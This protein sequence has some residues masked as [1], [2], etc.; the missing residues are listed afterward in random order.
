MASFAVSPLTPVTQRPYSNRMKIA[1]L[2]PNEVARLAALRRAKILDTPPSPAFDD[3]AK[4]AAFICGTPI[5]LVSLLDEDRQWFKAR[6]GLPISET[7]RDVAFCSHAI[8]GREVFEVGNALEDERFADNP[9]V[10][11]EAHVRFYAGAPLVDDDDHAL[12]T[13]C[14]I[15]SEPRTLTDAQKDA[16]AAL[17]RQ[18]MAQIATL[19]RAAELR[20][21]QQ[22]EAESNA[23]LTALVARLETRDRSLRLLN[24]MGD[25]LQSSRTLD[26]VHLTI[27]DFAERLFERRSGVVSTL[28]AHREDA[29]L[30][31]AWGPNRASAASFASDECWAIRRGRSHQSRSDRGVR[32]AH[33]GAGSH[34]CVPMLAGGEV[35]GALHVALESDAEA[36]EQMHVVEATA[37]RLA[38]AMANFRLR[39]SLRSQSVTDPLTGLYNRRY[40]DEVLARE[41]RRSARHKHPFTIAIIDV[42]HFKR[43]ND[44]IGHDGGDAV[45]RAIALFLRQNVRDEDLVCR[46]GGEEF[47]VGFVEGSLEGCLARAEALCRGVKALQIVH[48]G[49]AIGP[50]SISI[51]VGHALHDGV[52]PDTLLRAADG[53]LY[54]AKAEGR[55][56]VVVAPTHRASIKPASTLSRPRAA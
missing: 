13:L 31:A 10:T 4:V 38:L 40:L 47:V 50:V 16:L 21:L 3:I 18:V 15:D 24:E 39:D 36:I 14:V 2:P 34:V 35:R 48:A 52:T 5:A 55:D 22:A 1:P 12:G 29:R 54:R 6:I 51:G 8:L 9:L 42:D 7:P 32:C 30:I 27:T 33:L 46:Y 23:R 28:D 56:R 20:A 53:A 26:E 37:E 25:M 44:T 19:E 41:L 45:L 17:A 49:R 11:G 43:V